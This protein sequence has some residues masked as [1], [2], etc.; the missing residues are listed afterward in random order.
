MKNNGVARELPLRGTVKWFAKEKGY[1]FIE[2]SDGEKDVFVHY[3]DI[4]GSGRRDLEEGQFVEFRI[5]QGKR[6][7]KAVEVV[8][9]QTA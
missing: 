5:G 9:L 3:S 6:G 7:D 1:G 4:E 2:R 8:V